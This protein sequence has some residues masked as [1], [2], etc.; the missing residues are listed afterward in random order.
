[1]KTYLQ[2]GLAAKR[3]GLP[4]MVRGDSQ[5]ETPRSPLKRALKA[6]TYPRFLKLFDAALYVG[7]RSRSYYAHYGFPPDRLFFSPHCVDTAW[8]GTR[9][10]E[11]ERRRLR[12]LCHIAPETS[13]LLFAGKLVPFK[14]P[15]DL[16]LAAAKCRGQEVKAEVM[17]AGS[18]ALEPDLKA[19]AACSS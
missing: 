2:G 1:L 7:Q 19:A 13:A 5:L 10:T 18:G 11:T 3:L 15:V 14:R 12:G 8:F 16:V 17:I 9:A 4:L 6:W